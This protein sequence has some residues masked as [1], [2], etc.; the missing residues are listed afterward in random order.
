MNENIAVHPL[1][2]KWLTE[3]GYDYE[4]EYRMPVRGRVDFYATHKKDGHQ[5]LVEAKCNR[6]NQ[7]IK[8]ILGYGKQMPNAKLCIALPKTA[9]T[10]AVLQRANEHSIEIITLD[11]EEIVTQTADQRGIKLPRKT[12][13]QIDELIE[14]GYGSISHVMMLAV[15]CLYRAEIKGRKAEQIERRKADTEAQS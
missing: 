3:H 15:D 4:H 2:A 1:V 13:S 12:Y 6:R 14:L 9:V 5:L 7:V 11:I 8:Q 10:D